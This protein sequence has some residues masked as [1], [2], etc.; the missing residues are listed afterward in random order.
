VNLLLAWISIVSMLVPLLTAVASDAQG[1]L[2][3]R[4]D[5][6]NSLQLSRMPMERNH[7]HMPGHQV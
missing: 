6:R 1:L 7:Q 4:T 5:T 2:R 3:Q